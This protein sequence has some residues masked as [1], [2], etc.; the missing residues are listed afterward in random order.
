MPLAALARTPSGRYRMTFDRP[1][2]GTIA[3]EADVV[4][5]A[6]VEVDPGKHRPEEY[7]PPGE[8]P[9]VFDFLWFTPRADRP[10]PCEPLR[11]KG[12]PGASNAS[13]QAR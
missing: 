7:L 13:Q 1:G 11:R 12:F 8:G 10:D 5:L 4:V 6:M 3:L 9:P 2:G